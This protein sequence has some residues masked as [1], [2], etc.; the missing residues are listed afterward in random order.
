MPENIFE[1]IW[2]AGWVV[3]FFGVYTPHMRQF[4][5][6]KR[7]NLNSTPLDILLDFLA[8]GGWQV[9]P[10]IYIFSHWLDFVGYRLP[11]WTGWILSLIHI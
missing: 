6:V 7:T 3:Y 11:T 8:F 1:Y 2:L 5:A 10:L 9:I 4:R